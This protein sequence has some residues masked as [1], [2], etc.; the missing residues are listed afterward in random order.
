MKIQ[1]AIEIRNSRKN[2]TAFLH[3]SDIAQIEALLGQDIIAKPVVWVELCNQVIDAY[4][5]KLIKNKA[6]SEIFEILREENT[7]IRTEKYR[8]SASGLFKY[9]E[10]QRAYIFVK[11]C[12][13]KDFN[14][15]Y[16]NQY[17]D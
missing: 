4:D 3:R 1:E 2:V 15:H 11:P 9:D 16:A 6:F 13:R 14:L 7:Q 5:K 10:F 8:L 17:I 12:S